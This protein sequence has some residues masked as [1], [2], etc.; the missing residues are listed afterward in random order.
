MEGQF[1]VVLAVAPLELLDVVEV[2]D[3]LVGCL[4]FVLEL[5]GA[6]VEADFFVFLAGDVEL[7]V[8]LRCLLIDLHELVETA[9]LEHGLIHLHFV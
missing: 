8:E 2:G 5:V 1:L 4:V 9:D 3:A 6:A 7:L